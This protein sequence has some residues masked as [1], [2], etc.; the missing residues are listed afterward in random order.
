MRVIQAWR[1][2][3]PLVEA[4]PPSNYEEVLSTSLWWTNHFFG[5]NFGASVVRASF[6]AR[7]GIGQIADIWDHMNHSLLAWEDI[8][9]RFQLSAAAN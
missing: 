2:M 8:S 3:C 6:F 7:R 9:R 1:L 5:H 4:L